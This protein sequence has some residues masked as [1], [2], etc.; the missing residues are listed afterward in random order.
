MRRIV[1]YCGL[2]AFAG[3]AFCVGGAEATGWKV[4]ASY[5]APAANARG[6]QRNVP[7]AA[8]YCVLCDGSPPRIYD[9]FTPSQYINLDVPSGAHGFSASSTDRIWVSNRNNSY[10][11]NLSTAGSLISSFRCPKNGPADLGYDRWV[12]IPAENLAIRLDTNGS[13]VSS[14]AGPGSSLTGLFAHSNGYDYI[15]GDPDTHKI[16]FQDYGT[17]SLQSPIAITADMTT[18]KPPWGHVF[19]VDEAKNYVYNF[20]WYGQEPVAPASLGRVKGLFR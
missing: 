13:I 18:G 2:L 7:F 14:F 9:L 5:A 1:R 10:I 17:G 3:A 12:A 4:V 20:E 16:Y 11:Y 8:R 19:V 15:V 6:I